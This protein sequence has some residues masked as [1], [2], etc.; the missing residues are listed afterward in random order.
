MFDAITNC[1]AFLFFAA[2]LILLVVAVALAA[3]LVGAS[4]H[5]HEKADLT[6]VVSNFRLVKPEFHSPAFT[7]LGG[8]QQQ[9]GNNKKAFADGTTHSATVDVL[10]TPL[11]LHLTPDKRLFSGDYSFE[12]HGARGIHKIEIDTSRFLTGTIEGHAEAYCN[13]RVHDDSS[14]DG[15][16][17]LAGD[18]I[19]LEPAHRYFDNEDP[20]TT[21]VYRASDLVS[22]I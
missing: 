15:H 2:M 17:A 13:I 9:P 21:I 3:V 19:I 5:R 7:H 6:R 12:V 14:L 22:S 4:P 8:Q 20:G 1:L 11:T 10:G 18:R 16:I